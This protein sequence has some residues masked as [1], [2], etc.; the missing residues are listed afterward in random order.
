MI[1]CVLCC[2]RRQLSCFGKELYEILVS[3][4]H[5]FLMFINMHYVKFFYLLNLHVV[6]LDYMRASFTFT[7]TIFFLI[8]N[9]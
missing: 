6:R 5:S 4:L 1:L 8:R 9:V 3:V 7:L 2:T